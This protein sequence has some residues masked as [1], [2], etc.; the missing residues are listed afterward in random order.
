MFEYNWNKENYKIFLDYLDKNKDLKYREFHYKLLKDNSINFIGVRTPILKEVAKQ[1]SKTNYLEF[2]KLN[3]L[4]TYEEKT[5]YGLLLGYLKIDFNDLLKII[6]NYLV[7]I[8][9]WATCDLT[10]AN[11]KIFKKN[12][13]IGFNYLKTKINSNNIWI[14]RFVIVMFLDYFLCDEYIDD[15]LKMISVINTSEYYVEMAMAWLLAT[16]YINYQNKVLNLLESGKISKNVIILTI[17]KANESYRITKEKK[18]LIR[19]LQ[20]KNNIL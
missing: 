20:E 13:E 12:K 18:V 4:K 6:D 14:Q 9:N 11:L 8:D 5:I 17:K 19:K 16:A 10:C 2:I 7:N 1:I 3:T 15:V